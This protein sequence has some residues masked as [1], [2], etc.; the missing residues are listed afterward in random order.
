MML[1]CSLWYD[2]GGEKTEASDAEENKH[3]PPSSEAK[4]KTRH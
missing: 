3:R 4:H 2:E 1:T